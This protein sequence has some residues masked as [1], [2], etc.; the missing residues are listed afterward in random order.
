MKKIKIYLKNIFLGFII[1]LALVQ[2]SSAKTC[3]LN[4]LDKNSSDA[5]KIYH[6]FEHYH[7]ADYFSQ[8]Q[9][10]DI[11]KCFTS[12]DYSE[13]L[14]ISHGSSVE[15]AF[16]SY[17]TPILVK[18]DG[19]K[20]S[21]PLRFF[22]K[23]NESLSPNVKKVRVGLCGI[24]FSLKDNKIFSSM[25]VLLKNMIKKNIEVETSKKFRLAS[26]FIK[27]NV[28]KIDLNWLALSIS[29]EDAKKFVKW[30][31]PL[32]PYCK[33]DFWNGCDRENAEIIIPLSD[34]R[35]GGDG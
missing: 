23:I 31:T 15:S 22:E 10:S 16:S 21:L 3:I 6:L 7:E 28:T 19:N 4:L 18:D 2:E 25:D 34:K 20:I 13:I 9:V 12:G 5:Q 1:S 30:K 8:A 17:S 32:N 24:D 14:W 29:K 27:E 35:D 11:K 26:F 33:A